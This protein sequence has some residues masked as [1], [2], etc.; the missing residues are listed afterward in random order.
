MKYTDTMITFREVPDEVSLCI[1][2]SGCPNRCNGCHSPEL[3]E[4]IGTELN[5]ESLTALIDKNEGITCVCFMGGDA[6]PEYVRKL[7]LFVKT[8]YFSIKTCWY[9]GKTLTEINDV[10]LEPYDYIKV[11]PYKEE[12]GGLDSPST[13]Q[14][15]FIVYRVISPTSEPHYELKNITNKFW[16]NEQSNS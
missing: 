14:R 2:I 15:F 9:S 11:G 13:N 7:A 16:K 3:W 10:D 6:D 5:E 1:N 12:L 4:D 8:H